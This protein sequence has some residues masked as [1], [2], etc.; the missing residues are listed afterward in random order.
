MPD[1]ELETTFDYKFTTRQ[2]SDG[3]PVTFASG[4]VEIYEDNSVT[5]ITGAETLTIDFDS[6][7]GLHNLRIAA[8]A[9]NGFAVD[10]SYAAVVSAGTVGGTSVVGEV[11]MNFTIEKQMEEVRSDVAAIHSQTTVIESDT[12][13]IESDTT[14]IHSQTTVVES[15]SIVIESSVQAVETDTG[16]IYSDTTI[17]ASDAVLIYSDTTAI[18][19]QTTVIESDS[20]VI[21]GAAGGTTVAAIVD[22]T[23]DEVI[24]GATH[25]VANSSGRRLRQIEATFVVAS[26][27]AQAGTATTITLAAG[28]SATDDIFRGDR[29]VITEGTGAGEHDIITAYNGTTKVATVAETWVI[30]P[31]ATSVYELTPASVDVETWQHSTVT[32][33]GDM[34]QVESD[35]TV[36]ESDTTVIESDTTAIEAAGGSLTAAQ[37]SKLT[38]V[39]SDV[40]IVGSDVV[41]IYSDT[42][43]IHSDTTIIASDVVLVYSDTAAIHSDTAIIASDAVLIYSDTTAIHS[44]TTVI[45][46]DS[47]LV[48][49]LRVHGTVD[50]AAFTP[51]TTEF[52][53]DDI[54]EATPDHYNGRIVIFTSGALSGQATDITDYALS[55]ANG[56]FTVT[57]LTEA[58]GNNDTFD[59]V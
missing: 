59:I 51:T 54:T 55:G 58:P 57:A 19:S 41:L 43:A 47:V 29:I 14:A 8:T 23:W 3:A 11:I 2:F 21:E 26:G 52:E 4:A 46:S 27:T 38:K 25:N 9:A 15:D 28:E 35:L 30:T 10:S 42:T 32:G 56:H 24:T 31:D 17:I 18:H 6:I 13:V 48:E 1:F 34:A 37:D 40:V 33:T 44:Q 20:T 36:I 45:E 7:T 39:A 16:N 49:A 12:T 53:A 22:S 5:Q 50:T